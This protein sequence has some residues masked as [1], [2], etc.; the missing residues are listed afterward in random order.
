MTT[1][2][3][4]RSS[5]FIILLLHLEVIGGWSYFSKAFTSSLNALVVVVADDDDNV[6]VVVKEEYEIF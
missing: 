4:K 1:K 6:V 5:A 3:G 2:H